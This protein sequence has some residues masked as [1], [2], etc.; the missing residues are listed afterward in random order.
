MKIDWKSF[1]NTAAEWHSFWI[2]FFEILCPCPA[3]RRHCEERSD[4]AISEEYH[5]YLFGRGMAVIAWLIIA[6]LIQ[7]IFW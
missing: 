2:G 6:K 5:Y 3:N 7:A 4:E 1:M